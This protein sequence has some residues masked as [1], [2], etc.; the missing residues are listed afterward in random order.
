[1]CVTDHAAFG[2]EQGLSG[3]LHFHRRERSESQRFTGNDQWVKGGGKTGDADAGGDESQRQ[4]P[5]DA[6]LEKKTAQR[7]QR[8]ACRHPQ[9]R[10]IR[11]SRLCTRHG[12]RDI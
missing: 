10:D 1:M 5:A 7:Q 12:C 3:L 2:H 6:V 8:P 11:R 9:R 4:C